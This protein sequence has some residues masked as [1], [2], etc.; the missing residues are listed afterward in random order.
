VPTASGETLGFAESKSAMGELIGRESELRTARQLLIDAR[1]QSIARVLRVVGVSGIGKTA[2]ATR[3]AADAATDGWLGALISAHRIQATLPLVVARRLTGAIVEA[4]ETDAP[5]YTSGLDAE[6]E[7]LSA[8]S[9]SDEVAIESALHRLLEAILLDRPVL[10]IIDDAQWADAAS[11][12]LLARLLQAYADRP[13]VLVYVERSDEV[14]DQAFPFS[15]AAIVVTEFDRTTAE[16]LAR[17]LLPDAS[18]AVVAAIADHARGRAIDIVAIAASIPNSAKT[19]PDAV[20]ASARSVIARDLALLPSETREFL[21]ICS[22]IGEPIDYAILNELW[23]DEKLMQL[24]SISSGRFLM[25]RGDTLEFVHAAIAQSVRET[26]AIEIPYRRRIID[27]L[28]RLPNAGLQEYARLAEQAAACGD[29]ALELRYF[30]QLADEA[31]KANAL[32]LVASAL[33]RLVA[34][35]PFSDPESLGLYGRLAIAYNAANR[36]ADAVRIC[37]EVLDR[38]AAA[39]VVEGTGPIISSLLFALWNGAGREEFERTYRRYEDALCAPRDRALLLVTSLFAATTHLDFSR[40]ETALRQLEELGPLGPALEGRKVTFQGLGEALKGDFE[41]SQD[42][43]IHARR[44]AH[45]S[46]PE[47]ITMIDTADALVSFYHF[48]VNDDRVRAA[49]RRL[50]ETDYHRICISALESIA[51]GRPQEAIEVVA[52]SLIHEQ[53]AHARRVMLGV[54]TAAAV[55]GDASLPLHV[56]S[57]AKTE[58]ELLLRGS[59][60][61]ALYPIACAISYIVR[62]NEPERARALLEAAAKSA[63]RG[64]AAPQHFWM[65]C[66]LVRAAAHVEDRALLRSV[67]NSEFRADSQR[68]NVAHH[69][70]ASQLAKIALGQ[71][72]ERSHSDEVQRDFARLGAPFFASLASPSQGKPSGSESAARLSKREREITELVAEGLT[73]RQVAERLVL[74]ERTVE[75][76][77]ANIFNKLDVSSRSQITAWYIRAAQTQSV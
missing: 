58:A 60:D 31:T 3:I 23:P 73:N 2:I 1:K 36:E 13:F 26:V 30:T 41:A 51:V 52:E 27:A 53:G 5:R 62:R 50:S 32:P 14:T 9:K 67:A 69:N 56:L 12:G 48:G 34:L 49:I 72:L 61:P 74:S 24:I 20:L 68:W 17:M 71:P 15:D 8:S 35:I 75:G 59:T 42:A 70:L 37:R 63:I 64:P 18:S 6:I 44:I 66:V 43:L 57:T 7:S 76:H 10:F 77:I 22:L 16:R 45:E 47:L 21:Q 65:P 4:L 40:A 19:S 39:G 38:A 29:R 33:E 25:Q 11:R 55:L 28:S 46:A 54:A